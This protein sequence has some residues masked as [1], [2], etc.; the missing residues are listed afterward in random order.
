MLFPQLYSSEQVQFTAK[1]LPGKPDGKAQT[2]EESQETCPIEFKTRM[3]SGKSL[4]V[5]H[6]DLTLNFTAFLFAKPGA[7]A[8]RSLWC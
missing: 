3:L 6:A 2:D 4:K 8:F 5:M 1:P 7:N